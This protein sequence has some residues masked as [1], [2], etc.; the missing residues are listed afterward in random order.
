MKLTGNE[1]NHLR[2]AY[3]KLVDSG[4][5]KD[6]DYMKELRRIVNK[7]N[8]KKKQKLNNDIQEIILEVKRVLKKSDD[9]VKKLEFEINKLKQTL[10]LPADGKVN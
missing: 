6:S 4:E 2:T 9:R 3:W 8:I 10:A 1:F 5:H 7:G